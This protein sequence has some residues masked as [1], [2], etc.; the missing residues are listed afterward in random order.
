MKSRK[1]R[2]A[3]RLECCTL[4]IV[5]VCNYAPETV[6]FAH[7][8]DE[9]NGMAMKATDFSG[10]FACDACH[11]AVDRRTNS[12]ELESNRDWYLRRSQ[13]RTLERLYEKGVIRV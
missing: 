5:G 7:F 9:S 8:P 11:N 4:N 13:T 2:D 10:G 6:V 3:A 1:I 12:L